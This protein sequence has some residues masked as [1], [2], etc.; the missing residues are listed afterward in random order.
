MI[1]IDE[2]I[3]PKGFPSG[4]QLVFTVFV[5]ASASTPQADDDRPFRE[6]VIKAARR[7]G[8]RGAVTFVV[9]NFREFAP[10][11]VNEPAQT[12]IDEMVPIAGRH[13]T[14]GLLPY[15]AGPKTQEEIRNGLDARPRSAVFVYRAPRALFLDELVDAVAQKARLDAFAEMEA[16]VRTLD[17]TDA[18]SCCEL[19]P[20]DGVYYELEKQIERDLS[21]YADYW[22]AAKR[23]AEATA[24]ATSQSPAIQKPPAHDYP[25]YKGLHAYRPAD[26]GTFFG[27]EWEIQ[28]LLRLAT[29]TRIPV[30][31]L[32]GGSGV[33]K[34]S[35]VMAGLLPRMFASANDLATRFLIFRPQADP[36]LALALAIN[37]REASNTQRG[38]RALQ[39][40][41]EEMAADQAAFNRLLQ[42]P[43]RAATHAERNVIYIDQLEEL[44]ILSEEGQLARRVQFVRFLKGFLEAHPSCLLVTTIRDDCD[45]WL[46]R[47][48]WHEFGSLLALGRERWVHEPDVGA[49]LD[50]IV[51]GPS[52]LAAFDV[53]DD[54]I[55]ALRNDVT[56]ERCWTPLLSACLEEIVRHVT[57]LS[58]RERKIKL[59]HYVAVGTLG[60]VIRRRA[61]AVM[62]ELSPDE[63]GIGLPRLFSMLVR[64]DGATGKATKARIDLASWKLDQADRRLVD[65]LLEARL[66]ANEG[67]LEI[68]HD[69]L[70]QAW[71]DLHEWVAKGAELLEEVTDLEHRARRWE[72][73]DPKHR[74]AFL[75]SGEQ[76]LKAEQALSAF[77]EKAVQWPTMADFVAASRQAEDREKLRRAIL[78]ADNI[79]A[80]LEPVLK[81]V[82]LDEKQIEALEERQVFYLALYPDQIPEQN[83]MPGQVSNNNN[84]A[85]RSF[86]MA[87][88]P[89]A[90]AARLEYFTADRIAL[91]V[92]QGWTVQ[93]FAALAGQVAVLEQ[94]RSVGADLFAENDYL[95]T[96]LDFASAG[97]HVGVVKWLRQYSATPE[98]ALVRP[99]KLGRTPLHRAAFFGH[100][101]LV[102]YILDNTTAPDLE[103]PDAEGW[104]PLSVAAWQGTAPVLEMLAV[105]GRL[106]FEKSG[107][108]YVTPL[109]AA[110]SREN[111]EIVRFVLK[112][113]ADVNDD[114]HTWQGSSPLGIAIWNGNMEIVEEL[115]ADGR[116]DLKKPVDAGD[117]ALVHALRCDRAHVAQR[118][119]ERYDLAALTREAKDP[120]VPTALGCA[121]LNGDSGM[122]SLLLQK[123]ANPNETSKGDPPICLARSNAA[124]LELLAPVA[125]LNAP[126]RMG[127]SALTLAAL[128]GNDASVAFLLER[129]A[130]VSSCPPDLLQRVGHW[131]STVDAEARQK[132][133]TLLAQAGVPTPPFKRAVFGDEGRFLRV[134]LDEDKV[135]ERFDFADGGNGRHLRPLLSGPWRVLGQSSAE[136][137]LFRLMRDAIGEPSAAAMQRLKVTAVASL[138]LSFYR[139]GLLYEISLVE[140]ESGEEYTLSVVEV[141][142]R[143]LQLDGRSNPI[144]EINEHLG[145]QLPN[146]AAALEY[147]RFFCAALAGQAGTFRWCE[148]ADDL[149]RWPNSSAPSDAVVSHF[150]RPEATADTGEE[151]ERFIVRASYQYSGGIYAGDF[152]VRPNGLIEMLEDEGL[153]E[154]RSL[155]MET[156]DGG[157][158]TL[159]PLPLETPPDH[160]AGGVASENTSS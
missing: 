35:L 112:H 152:A 105:D 80:V 145:L 103:L 46:G 113:T 118:L 88:R 87:V 28:D 102:R 5:A 19:M 116:F 156:F 8:D 66:L 137:L 39:V 32:K 65:R 13:I 69:V 16:F 154:D 104:T 42:A 36:F 81:G 86:D 157:L 30:L 21:N 41:A 146:A 110:A 78:E 93:H 150:K 75:L 97:G 26:A 67:A 153:V 24:R 27:R 58:L 100:A 72:R 90:I 50:N 76:L 132:I 122:V 52:S 23:N 71:D 135:R 55:A 123:G 25:K 99:N 128:F 14:I 82:R 106:G 98:T 148:V 124:V 129:G 61:E 139:E 127:R 120:S 125:D 109:N 119:L 155:P 4:N 56:A 31:H 114:L 59:E 11:L 89:E 143:S 22:L 131:A 57:T 94:L 130:E 115:L 149:A 85:M 138:P 12:L 3:V 151:G 29:D 18:F 83:P 40:L 107:V 70:F 91:H 101:E 142:G 117:T 160:A 38:P 9:K 134:D 133:A 2:R 43:F 73:R 126:D 62:A 49:G 158:R 136:S 7:V 60:G 47:A 68:I 77:P 111:V 1:T 95:A 79:S 96:P 141:F 147:A 64:I 37:E 51:R 34:S 159:K 10:P 63:R 33:G 54:L 92:G 84:G 48:E 6:C 121:I 45:V 15:R 144:H 74:N 20:G 17:R 108:R 140:P 44:L 53:D